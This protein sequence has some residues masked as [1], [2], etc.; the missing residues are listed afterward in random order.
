MKFKIMTL[1][2]GLLLLSCKDNSQKEKITAL[3]KEWQGKQ[4]KFPKD[5]TFTKYVTDTTDFQIPTKGHKVLI[6]VDSLGC[7]S[8]KLQLAKWNEFIAY[9]DSAT[10]GNVPFLF[11]IHSKNVDETKY[12]LKIDEF[13]YP[14]CI[15]DTD[16][17]NKLN[18]FP[19]NSIFQTF[20]LDADNKVVVLGNPIHNLSVKELYIKEITGKHTKQTA[21]Q[22]TTAIADQTAFDLGKFALDDK[23]K[24]SFTLTN[25]GDFPLVIQDILTTCDC[26]DITF[27]KHP[28]RTKE[29]LTVSIVMKGKEKGFFSKT[30]TVYANTN[31]PIK[32]QIKGYVQ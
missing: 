9:T 12:L 25:T 24:N 26:M 10:G 27:E 15:D 30:V 31:K 17:L 16:Q 13:D 23:K 6:Y 7:T 11:F 20:L 18:T 3:V 1:F 19:S 5:P 28:V 8:C 14:I 4:I 29:K 22:K 21:Q 2:L 32:I